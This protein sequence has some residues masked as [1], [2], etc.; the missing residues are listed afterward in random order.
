MKKIVIAAGFAAIASMSATSAMAFDGTV[1]FTGEILDQACTVDIG[2]DNTL[3]VDLGKVYKT[4][5]TGV[6][7]DASTTKFTIKLKDCPETVTS[8]KVKFD[9]APDTSDSDLLALDSAADAASGVAIK[10]MT[11][12]K[13]AL[14]LHSVN[15]YS[16]ALSSTSENNLDFYAAYRSTSATVTAGKANSVANFTVNYN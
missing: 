1:K 3:T 7:T 11:A 9:G 5:F 2:T 10:L 6:G 13:T 14:P 16:Y 12:D 4:A 8:A 15:D